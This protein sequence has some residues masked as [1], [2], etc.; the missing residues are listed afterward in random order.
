M[1]AG[2]VLSWFKQEGD[3]VKKGE[4]LYELMTDKAA[5]EIESPEDGIVARILVAEGTECAVGTPVAAGEGENNGRAVRSS[6]RGMGHRE[7]NP[8]PE[9]TEGSKESVKTEAAG[10]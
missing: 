6:N 2:T 3:A 8:A 10:R 9:A 5:L 4:P 7:T 1:T